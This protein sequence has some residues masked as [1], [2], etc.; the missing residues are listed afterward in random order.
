MTLLDVSMAVAARSVEKSMGVITIEMKTSFM[1]PARGKLRG[2]GR[3]MHRTG[4][5]AFM[6]ATIFDSEGRACAQ[7]MGTFKYV[8]RQAGAASGAPSSTLISTD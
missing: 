5:M 1:H 3:L 2:K 7:A 8:K 4:S 6:E